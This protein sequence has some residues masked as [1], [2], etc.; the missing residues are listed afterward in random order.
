MTRRIRSGDTS[1][2]GNLGAKLGHRGRRLQAHKS[3][4]ETIESTQAGDPGLSHGSSGF[5]ILNGCGERCDV[6][7]DRDRGGHDG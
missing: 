7:I 6:A 5:K 4:N 3:V 2:G 1:G